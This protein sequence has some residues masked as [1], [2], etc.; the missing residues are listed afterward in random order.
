MNN[1]GLKIALWLPY[2]MT[3][4]FYGIGVIVIMVRYDV[5]GREMAY[6]CIF[7]IT[8]SCLLHG[9]WH[10]RQKYWRLT[11]NETTG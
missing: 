11:K 3:M 1:L 6:V 4:L 7:I 2:V 10:V 9:S 8:Y 5:P